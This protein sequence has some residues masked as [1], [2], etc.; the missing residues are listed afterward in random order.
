MHDPLF[1]GSFVGANN[2]ILDGRFQVLSKASERSLVLSDD[3]FF[4]GAPEPW[5]GFG[6]RDNFVEGTLFAALQREQGSQTDLIPA[7]LELRSFSSVILW[8][9]S[10]N[11]LLGWGLM[12]RVGSGRP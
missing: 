10:F 9:R 12:Q 2:H 8:C 6:V 5:W 3:F 1:E 11:V 4:D 7:N